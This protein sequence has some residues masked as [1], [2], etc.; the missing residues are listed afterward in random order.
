MRAPDVRFA[1]SGDVR[2]AWIQFGSGPDVLAIPPLVSNVELAW[3]HELYR[4]FLE[5]QAGHVRVTAFDKRGIGLSDKFH[6]AP[7]LQ[8]RT[9]DVAAVMDAAGLDHAAIVGHSE[10]ALMAQLFAAQ[11][12]DRVD[13]LVLVNAHPGTAGFVEAHR[14]VDGEFTPLDRKLQRFG[15]LIETWGRD[16]QYFV[17]WFASSHSQNDAFVRWMGRYQ[18]HSATAADLERQLQSLS[19]LDAAEELA[20]IS[21]PTLIIHAI[22][23]PVIP[24][25]SSRYLAARIPSAQLVEVTGA[26]HLA[27]VA[28]N[29]EQIADTWIEFATG[30]RPVRCAQRRLA[31]IVFTDIVHSTSRAAMVGDGQWRRVL[32]RHDQIAWKLADGHGG[33]IVKTTGDGILARFDTP[34]AGVQF[35]SDLRQALHDV[36]LTIRCGLHSGEIEL[37][38]NGDVSGTAVNL[39][40]RVMDAAADGSIFVSSTVRELLLGGADK[41]EARGE[42]VLKGFEH[43]WRLYELVS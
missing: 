24:I 14:D 18:R 23:D 17:D 34:S 36:D 5:Y 38:D 39:A 3:E 35:G 31:T 9:D 29:W 27:E 28:P 21:V 13:R 32:D 22:D 41:F 30:H 12:P 6:D 20:E 19:A 16:P 10:G 4:R 42:H 8:Q 7:T 37:R 11:C 40:A 26:D 2:L 25:A 33:A 43:A 15:R 1:D